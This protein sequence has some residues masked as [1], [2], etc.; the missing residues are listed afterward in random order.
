MLVFG[1][2][3]G[4]FKE[5][6][7]GEMLLSSLRPVTEVMDWWYWTQEPRAQSYAAFVEYMRDK[8]DYND[9]PLCCQFVVVALPREF[10]ERYIAIEEP[11]LGFIEYRVPTY[12]RMFGIPFCQT[13]AFECWW[14]Y[15]PATA[16]TRY[17]DM[18]LTASIPVSFKTIC[19]HLL[20]RDGTRVFH[21]FYKIFPVGIGSA[22]RFLTDTLKARRY[23]Q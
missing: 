21:P 1:P 12:A 18:T 22:K 9:V 6:K 15:E 8:L 7:A 13:K 20:R 16:D 17:R 4:I 23:A 2:V 19:R 10:L 5:L 14:P 3:T 11:E